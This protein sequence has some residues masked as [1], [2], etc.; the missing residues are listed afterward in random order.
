LTPAPNSRQI[1]AWLL[2]A[3]EGGLQAGLIRLG[4]GFGT[5]LAVVAA[6]IAALRVTQ[7][8]FLNFNF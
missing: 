3:P 7:S 1:S 4:L 6:L 8:P 2:P 5:G